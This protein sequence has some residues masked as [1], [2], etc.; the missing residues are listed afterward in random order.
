MKKIATWNEKELEL[1]EEFDA[2]KE[3][4]CHLHLEVQARKL[5]LKP[6]A[7]ICTMNVPP[8]MMST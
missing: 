5:K 2:E 7:V 6:Y 4:E 3:L 8:T 1:G